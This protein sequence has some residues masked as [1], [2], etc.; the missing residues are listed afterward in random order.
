MT[1]FIINFKKNHFYI[2][3]YKIC[4]TLQ[5]G[6]KVRPLFNKFGRISGTSVMLKGGNLNIIF[7]STWTNRG[8]VFYQLR[9]KYQEDCYSKRLN[10]LYVIK[11]LSLKYFSEILRKL[12]VRQKWKNIVLYRVSELM[13]VIMLTK[14]LSTLCCA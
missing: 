2:F 3:A 12:I 1:N 5:D 8:N 13:N 10:C 4:K 9:K 14:V 7:I 6:L 11:R